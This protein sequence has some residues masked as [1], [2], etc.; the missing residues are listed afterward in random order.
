M[1]DHLKTF[2]ALIVSF[3]VT[4]IIIPRLLHI[5]SKLDL[6]DHPDDKRKVHRNPKPI[7]GGIGMVIGLSISCLLF[8]PSGGLRGFYAGIVL[9]TIIGFLDDFR[10][11][12]H[13]WKFA[14]QIV[15]ALFIVYFS[16]LILTYFGNL[17]W[18]GRISFQ[19]SAI[20]LTIFS[21]VGV[22]NAINMI[23]GID[24]L[25]GGVSLI[26]FIAFALLAAITN[27]TELMILSIACCGTVI[28]FLRYNWY[29]SKGDAGSLPLGFAL[30]FIAIA[31]TQ[32]NRD[33]V[34]PVAPLFI[35]TVPIVDTL[36]VMTKRV[37][38]D[39]SPFL[40]DNTHLHHILL[41]FGY[42]KKTTVKIILLL[43]AIFS[44]I[45]IAGTVLKIPEYILFGFFLVYFI[46]YFIASFYIKDMLKYFKKRRGQVSTFDIQES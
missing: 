30:T 16:D 34:P 31:I 27:Q 25:A 4:L 21:T 8:V 10:E 35:L 19:K 44:V 11:I 41:R 1:T 9:L 3:T 43:T 46:S 13:R 45:G 29:P 7:I 14:A 38:H 20:L 15:A 5:A 39:K 6:I 42:D 37:M 23:D 12:N 33:F 22:I 17:L 36:T 24:G 40:P 32:K 26:A 2:L 28:A 18:F